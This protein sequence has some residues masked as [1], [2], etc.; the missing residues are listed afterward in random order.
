MPATNTEQKTFLE[1]MNSLE[2]D[3]V[4]KVISYAAYLRHLEE[5]EEEEDIAYIEAHRGDPS[6]P[7]ED[8]LRE[9]GL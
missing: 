8:A 7:L 3:D 2:E 5:R 1:L 4:E 6:V 9:L